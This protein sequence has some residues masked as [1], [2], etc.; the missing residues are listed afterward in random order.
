MKT[1]PKPQNFAAYIGIDWADQK[2]DVCLVASGSEKLERSRIEHCPEALNS[3]IG[4]LRRRFRG[5]YVAI[6]VEQT[7]GGLVHSL[8]Q[9]EFIVLYLINPATSAKFRGAWKPSRAKDDVT[10]AE[11]LAEIVRL[12]RDRLRAWYPDDVLTRKL[13]LLCEHRRKAVNLRVKLTNQLRSALKAYYPLACQVCGDKLNNPMALRFLAKWPT[14]ESLKRARPAT[15]RQFYYRLNSRYPE[16][17]QRRLEQIASAEPLTSDEAIIES[18]SQQMLMLIDQLHVLQK[19]ISR[20]DKAIDELFAQHPD[21]AI[22]QSF[23]GSGKVYAP[24]LLAAFG[25]DRSRFDSAQNV[26]ALSGI[27]PVVESSGKSRWVHRRW[28]CVRFARQSF[29]EWASESIRHSIWARAWY[30]KAR[31]RGMGHHAAVRALAFKWIRIMF[32]CWKDKRPYDE[33]AYL[34]VL[35]KRNSSLWQTIAEHPEAV[36]IYRGESAVPA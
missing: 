21:Q 10:D 19:H 28:G 34:T 18:Y 25:S 16:T 26:Q 3:W 4:S 15:L 9:H 13:T 11:L 24:R 1:G 6:A 20:Y 7:R 22:F 33:L 12:H 29:H 30:A 14:F 5:K 31:E 36:K 2:H 17:I 8:M 35:K 32:R 23:P 27:A